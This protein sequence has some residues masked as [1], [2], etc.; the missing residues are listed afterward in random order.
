MIHTQYVYTNCDI[1]I[2]QLKKS[3]VNYDYFKFFIIHISV[4]II[5]TF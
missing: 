1:P 4:E 3:I 2:Y 5:G